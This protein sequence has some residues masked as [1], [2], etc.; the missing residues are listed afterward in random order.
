MGTAVAL[1][2][3]WVDLC[4]VGVMRAGVGQLENDQGFVEWAS[5]EPGDAVRGRVC[6]YT[7][8]RESSSIPVHR[9]E[10]PTGS[11]SLIVSF[12]DEFCAPAT[13]GAAELSTYTSF[14]VGMHDRPSPTVHDGRQF[15]IQIGLDP[16]G[17]FS[18]LGVPLHELG[19][20]VVELEELLG[21]DAERWAGQLSETPRWPDRF[22][23]LDRLLVER[24]GAGPQ[25]SPALVWAWR[26]M[27]SASGAV[28]IAE[29]ARG[30][31]CSHR[32][33]VAQFREQ[34]GATP[35]TAA[36]LLR[37]ARAARLLASGSLR[38]AQVA[39]LCGYADQSHLNREYATFAGT[40]PGAA[41]VTGGVD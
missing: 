7:G 20:R 8:Y 32:H 27:Q 35:K 14:A 36:R 34:V 9:L 4:T 16:C 28:Q 13:A 23:M 11:L 6:T 25:P 26:T 2:D 17:A 40:T 22:S 1:A 19:N 39:A 18:L 37:Y 5:G 30:A 15:G 29:L 3:G 38:P 10:T 31:G 21:A 33:L 24:M 12:G 41:A